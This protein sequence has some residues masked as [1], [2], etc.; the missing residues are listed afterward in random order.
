MSVYD[1]FW[2]K[3]DLNINIFLQRIA[4]VKTLLFSIDALTH[5]RRSP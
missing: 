3:N 5:T 2:R 4:P 1:L